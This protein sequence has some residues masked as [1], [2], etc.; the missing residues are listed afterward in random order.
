MPRHMTLSRKSYKVEDTG[1]G[2]KPR[3]CPIQNGDTAQVTWGSNRAGMLNPLPIGD[4][5]CS[6]SLGGLGAVL[7]RERDSCS[8]SPS[9]TLSCLCSAGSLA[10]PSLTQR[11]PTSVGLARSCWGGDPGMSLSSGTS[12][13]HSRITLPVNS[14]RSVPRPSGK[15]AQHRCCGGRGTGTATALPRP[16]PSPA[17]RCGTAAWPRWESRG[18]SVTKEPGRVTS[19]KGLAVIRRK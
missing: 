4:S 2:G 8:C 11:S 5:R 13:P 1:N 15:D 3:P 6:L 17:T 12:S 18:M 16:R 19:L 10:S 7:P 9:P 14:K